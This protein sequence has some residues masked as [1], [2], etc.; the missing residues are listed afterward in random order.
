[1]K[2]FAVIV[3]ISFVWLIAMPVFAYPVHDDNSD[4]RCL[5]C[6]VSLPFEGIELAFHEDTSDI[7]SKCHNRFS[8]VVSHGTQGLPHP[9]NIQPTMIIPEDMVLDV[10]GQVS[11]IT[12]HVFHEGKK[13]VEDMNLFYLRRPPGMRFCYA[14]H[15]KF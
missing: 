2:S 10:K 15:K 9:I 4:T 8:C 7:C 11:C 1:M 5:D 14:C 13:T 12:C 3:I 6:H